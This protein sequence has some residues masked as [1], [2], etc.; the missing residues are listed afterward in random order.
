MTSPMNKAD[1]D[2]TNANIQAANR[3]SQILL[4]RSCEREFITGFSNFREKIDSLAARGSSVDGRKYL[5]LAK[6]WHFRRIDPEVT[7]DCTA[8][9]KSRA[10]ISGDEPHEDKRMRY[11]VGRGLHTVPH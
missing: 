4:S 2:D 8:E 1:K 6:L 7:P 5:H 9:A 10:R 11:G 3:S